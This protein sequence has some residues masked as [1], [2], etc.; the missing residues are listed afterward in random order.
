MLHA[1]TSATLHLPP[2][3][4]YVVYQ[5]PPRL[6]GYAEF[7]HRGLAGSL[8]VLVMAIALMVLI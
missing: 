3:R 1:C 2:T 5:R 7:P 8:T 6:L 4:L